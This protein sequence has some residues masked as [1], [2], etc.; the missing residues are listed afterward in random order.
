[1]NASQIHTRIHAGVDEYTRRSL[2]LKRYLHSLRVAETAAGLS[3]RFAGY[4]GISVE[5]ARIAGVAHDMAREW[6]TEQLIVAAGRDEYPPTD[7]ELETPKLL[8]GKAAAVMLREEFGETRESVISAVRWHTYGHPDMG[9]LGMI[10]YIADYIEPGR[11]HVDE[12]YFR[13]VMSRESLEEMVLLVLSDEF[14]HLRRKGRRIV[15]S[16][17]MLYD[18]LEKSSVR[19]GV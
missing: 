16:S 10:I 5:E 17:R 4:Y 12:E 13:R 15:E 6:E 18:A 8:H 14:D 19:S 9:A 7:E 11:E 2:S 1:M 3:R